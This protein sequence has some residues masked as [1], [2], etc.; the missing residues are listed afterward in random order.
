[1]EYD[2]Q[3]GNLA[4]IIAGEVLILLPVFV[5]I[6]VCNCLLIVYLAS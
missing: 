3:A 4:Q 6:Y 5:T 1:M 2:N